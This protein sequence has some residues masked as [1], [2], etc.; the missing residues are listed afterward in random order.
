M[1]PSRITLSALRHDKRKSFDFFVYRSNSPDDRQI[2]DAFYEKWSLSHTVPLGV[3]YEVEIVESEKI[4]SHKFG[5]FV[6]LHK[7]EKTGKQFMCWTEPIES[8]DALIKVIK[9]WC[10]GSFYTLRQGIDFAKLYEEQSKDIHD[11][12]WLEI[13]LKTKF[14][15]VIRSVEFNF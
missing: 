8:E 9:T 4:L 15:F 6:H 2:E 1:I 3:H 13:F 11:F 5:K 14:N 10:L 7:S 12:D